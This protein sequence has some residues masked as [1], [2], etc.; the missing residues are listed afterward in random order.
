MIR[1]GRLEVWKS[2][3]CIGYWCCKP[4]WSCFSLFLSHDESHCR[5][6]RSNTIEVWQP[7]CVLH[8]VIILRPRAFS[9]IAIFFSQAFVRIGRHAWSSTTSSYK[10]YLAGFSFQD[11]SFGIVYEGIASKFHSSKY[12]VFTNKTHVFGIIHKSVNLQIHGD[13]FRSASVSGSWYNWSVR[14][15][16]VFCDSVLSSKKS[17]VAILI[18]CNW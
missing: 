15:Y 12:L 17:I 3:V 10:Q 11:I 14:F 5:E 16:V 9:D 6:Y 13:K 1:G 18:E 8:W 4:K 2:D 7:F